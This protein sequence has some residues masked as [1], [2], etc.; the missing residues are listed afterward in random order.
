MLCIIRFVLSSFLLNIFKIINRKGTSII[1]SMVDKIARFVIFIILH[2]TQNV[3]LHNL[4][5]TIAYNLVII[6]GNLIGKVNMSLVVKITFYFSSWDNDI[7]TEIGGNM[8]NKKTFWETLDI[9]FLKNSVALRLQ[10]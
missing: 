5:N 8:I 10:V 6:W 3:I 7:L 2:Y 4:E 9:C 1:I